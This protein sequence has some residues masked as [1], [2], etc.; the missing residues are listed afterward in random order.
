MSV[1]SVRQTIRLVLI[2]S[3]LWCALAASV[4]L[5]AFL[6]AVF[7]PL[8][9][10]LDDWRLRFDL[11]AGPEARLVIVDVDERS[12]AQHGAWPW[13]RPTI[14]RL[15]QILIDDYG[16]SSIAIDMVFPESRADDAILSQQLKRAPITGAVVFD[17]EHRGLP[18]LPFPLP[19]PI[20]LHID[21]DAPRVIGT[22]VVANHAAIMPARVGHINPVFDS[23]GAVRRVYP[24]ICSKTSDCLSTLTLH[25]YAG[26]LDASTY[27]LQ[28]GHGVLAPV[29]ELIVRA[30]DGSAMVTMPVSKDGSLV[31]PYRHQKQD[32][33][34]ISAV[35]ILDHKPQAA[36]L[37]G[38]MVL[39][40]G[41][42]LGLADVISTP[43]NPVAAG[44][45]P[46]A[47]IL[48]AL[49]DQDF[50]YV[51]RWGLLLDVL[52][53][54]PFC[55]L[56]A[57][58]LR[59][60][61]KPI[62]RVALFPSWFA[63]TWLCGAVVAIVALRGFNL[64]LPL[65]PLLLFPPLALA[66]TLSAELY[67]TGSERA[68]IFT[69]LSAYLPR[70]VAD[71]LVSVSNA[72][73]RLDTAVD[74]SRRE[75]TVIF[76]DIHGF[77]GLTEKESPEVVAR[78]MQRVFTEMAEAVVNHHGTI[79]KFIGDA[80]M[81]FWN[82]PEDVPHHAAHA[83]AAAQEMQDRIA[84]LD[85][86][87]ADLGIAAITIGIGIETGQALVGNFGSEHRRTFTAL[88]EP[89]VLASRIEALTKALYAPILIGEQCAAALNM[90]GVTLLGSFQLRGRTQPHKIYIAS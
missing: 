54:S 7:Q 43:I 45:E 38:V 12:I 84:R 71:R 50:A 25:A 73:A 44:L 17:L 41:T 27:V 14:A 3:S 81:A 52:L 53:L 89:V 82:A 56:L 67:R 36:L 88:G 58:L 42:A 51:P 13:S 9:H 1:F 34:S 49:L 74:A 90:Q 46:H 4:M 69:L 57:W 37:K 35:D 76:A 22:P 2:Q 23:D 78:L 59:R 72:G 55:L 65:S 63:L 21:A 61:N 79:D 31:V 39:M 26:M 16:V 40:G 80:I 28:R 8:D 87:C 75:I 19:S 77:V 10:A 30:E 66:L 18:A 60:F 70:P 20:R 32:W 33:V 5:P 86:F 15:L 85:A 68:G 24:L 47:E 11:R 64:L 6:P 62:Q 48:S 29:W 83:L